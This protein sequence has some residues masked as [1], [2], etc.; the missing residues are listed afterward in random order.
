MPLAGTSVD[1][2]V[3]RVAIAP[4]EA[5]KAQIVAIHVIEVRLNLPLDAI[6]DPRANG[7]GLLD[8]P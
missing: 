6:L 1:P 3:I 5:P 2:E 7:R 8:T 4:R